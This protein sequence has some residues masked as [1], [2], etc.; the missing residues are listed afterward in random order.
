MMRERCTLSIRAISVKAYTVGLI[1]DALSLKVNVK[2]NHKYYI[3]LK[4]LIDLTA[5]Y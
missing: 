2:L 4:D 3:C 5:K 1:N